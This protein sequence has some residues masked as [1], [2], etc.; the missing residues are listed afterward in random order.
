MIIDGTD[1]LEYFLYKYNIS[2]KD[3][4]RAYAI[5]NFYNEKEGIKTLN[6]VNLNKVLYYNGKQAVLDILLFKVFSIIFICS[7]LRFA[8]FV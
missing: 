1:N 8:P 6:E 4:K 7:L 2:K 5:N 3:Q